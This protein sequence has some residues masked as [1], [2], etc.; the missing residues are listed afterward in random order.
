MTMKGILNNERVILS[1]YDVIQRLKKRNFISKSSNDYAVLPRDPDKR[2]ILVHVDPR[3]LVGSDRTKYFSLKT[4]EVRMNYSDMAKAVMEGK[5]ARRATWPESMHLWFACEMMLHTHP[6]WPDQG[7]VL[8]K[9]NSL[10]GFPYI[11]EKD[12]AL[13]NDWELVSA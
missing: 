10:E 8:F 12:D 13:T 4:K 3:Y 7:K 2:I 1:N 5:K 6:Y 11:C 9:D